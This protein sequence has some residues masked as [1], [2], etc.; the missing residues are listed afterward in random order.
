MSCYQNPYYDENK[1]HHTPEGFINTPKLPDKGWKDFW[2]WRKE[3]KQGQLKA[4][5]FPE[6]SPF[7]VVPAKKI[8]QALVRTPSSAT[9]LG[10][11]SVLVAMDQ[12]WIITDP[13]FTTH[14]SPVRFAG[15]KRYTPPPMSL[16]EL[17]PLDIVLISH[18]HYDHLDAGTVQAIA[19]HPKHQ[20]ATFVVPLGYKTWLNKRGIQKVVE[21]DWWASTHV[22]G[23]ELTCAPV[24]HWTKRTPWDTNRRLWSGWI[25]VGQDKR[26]YFA[27]DTGYHPKHF[28]EVGRQWGPFDL[29]ALPIGAYEPRWFMKDSHM[30][31]EEAILVH[32]ELEAKQSMGIHWGTFIL[33]DEPLTEPP[34]LLDA[35]TQKDPSLAPFHALMHGQTIE[36]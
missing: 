29:A 12:K 23:I 34:Q 33:T 9:W 30:N 22:Q 28:K 11:A 19:K 13:H 2:R 26:F 20:N 17:P 10:H 18:D 7:E 1:A 25:V 5:D 6:V 15:P 21:L 3:R 16:D 32:Q 27:G 36:F 14:A 4:P 8:Q 24:Q 35:L 31:V